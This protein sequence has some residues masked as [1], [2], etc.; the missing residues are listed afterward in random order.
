MAVETDKK[1]NSRMAGLDFVDRIACV[2]EQDGLP[3][4]GAQIFGLLM[5]SEN[6]LS[7]D[8]VSETLEVSKASVSINTRLLEQRGVIEK[9]TRRGDRRDF[10]RIAPDLFQR[11]MQQR[12]ARWQRIHNL[13]GESV[14]SLSLPAS[15]KTRLVQ[16]Q[17]NSEK[18]QRLVEAAMD[19][20]GAG[21]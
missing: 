12:L 10:Y 21:R 18:M 9:V 16:F 6:D 14:A 17:K 15:V 8:E 4:I 20:D 3:R 11:T 2:L 5:I 13:V 7:L 1:K 19:R